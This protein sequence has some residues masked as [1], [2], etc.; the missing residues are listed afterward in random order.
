YP[1]TLKYHFNYANDAFGYV[2]SSDAGTKIPDRDVTLKLIE[3]QIQMA[4]K[5][6]PNDVNSNW[7][8]GQY[9]Y[10]RAIDTK[11]IAIAIK[12]TKPEDVKKKADLNAQAKDYFSKAV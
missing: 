11:E 2:Y 4:L 3:D 6:N 10:N 7:L 8:Y 5:I 12:G 9:F 1:D